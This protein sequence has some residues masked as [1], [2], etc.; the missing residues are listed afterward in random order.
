MLNLLKIMNLWEG[1]QYLH[2]WKT[3][4]WLRWV[5][6]SLEG[7]V[8]SSKAVTD[9]KRMT[10]SGALIQLKCCIFCNWVNHSSDHFELR[11]ESV[12]REVG[13]IFR[14]LDLQTKAII[15]FNWG[16]SSTFLDHSHSSRKSLRCA[17]CFS[18][19]LQSLEHFLIFLSH[20][21]GLFECF[22]KFLHFFLGFLAGMVTYIPVSHAYILL[23]HST[24][25]NCCFFT[26]NALF[27]LWVSFFLG[28]KR[29]C[30]CFLLPQ[31]F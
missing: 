20:R 12:H 21:L 7:A 27:L 8:R 31:L 30:S 29:E 3:W 6:S 25:H 28:W 16:I 14:G 26:H 4:S 10:Y 24:C 19:E 5:L 18:S 15:W 2:S 9:D 22:R 1:G 11:E 23:A 13:F 17:F